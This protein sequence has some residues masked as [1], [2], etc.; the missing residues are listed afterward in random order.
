MKIGISPE[1]VDTQSRLLNELSGYTV[2]VT[3]DSAY[4]DLEPFDAELIGPDYDGTDTDAILVR[5]WNEE[6]DEAT[7]EPIS[8]IATE[9]EVY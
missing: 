9:I 4:H 8:I 1:A 5:R 6:K 7:G 3:P 2:T